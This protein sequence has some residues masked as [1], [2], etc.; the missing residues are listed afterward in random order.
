MT[1]DRR[2]LEIDTLRHFCFSYFQTYQRVSSRW[3]WKTNAAKSAL[4]IN[5]APPLS[6]LSLP[7]VNHRHLTGTPK[8]SCVGRFQT[9]KGWWVDSL[10]IPSCRFSILVPTYDFLKWY[11][12]ICLW[13]FRNDVSDVLHVLIVFSTNLNFGKLPS[14][15]PPPPWDNLR[16]CRPSIA[17]NSPK[18][19][20]GFGFGTLGQP[21]PHAADACH[22]RPQRWGCS[23]VSMA[24]GGTGDAWLHDSVRL[25]VCMFVCVN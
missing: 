1:G 9:I 18:F 6:C 23:V 21:G 4:K 17:W 13:V 19:P 10:W 20:A 25:C 2:F 14:V 24:S 15:S 22:L 12:G 5:S 16:F 8:L 3:Q 7:W 11:C